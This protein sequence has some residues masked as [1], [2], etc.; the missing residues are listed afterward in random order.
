[1]RLRTLQR[2][3][4][5]GLIAGISGLIAAVAAL[6]VVSVGVWSRPASPAPAASVPVY[7]YAEHICAHQVYRCGLEE[8]K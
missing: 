6:I 8:K 5:I 7:V 2:R 3:P 1:M 4:T